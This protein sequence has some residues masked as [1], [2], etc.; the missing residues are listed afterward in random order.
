[1]NRPAHRGFAKLK[2][3]SKDKVM[4]LAVVALIGACGCPLLIPSTHART[5]SSRKG[6]YSV[7]AKYVAVQDG[8]VILARKDES[9]IEVPL[10]KLSLADLRYIDQRLDAAVGVDRPPPPAEA[11]I[12]AEFEKLP[13]QPLVP[14]NGLLYGRQ[15][16]RSFGYTFTLTAEVGQVLDQIE[17]TGNFSFYEMPDIIRGHRRL[18]P[19][20]VGSGTGFVVRA[21]GFLVT[22]AHVVEDATRVTVRFGERSYPGRVVSIVP[23]FDLAVVRIPAKNLP[24]L[25]IS[26]SEEPKPGEKVRAIG[27]P[28]ATVLGTS[29]KATRGSITRRTERESSIDLLQVDAAINPGNSGGPLVNDRGEVVGIIHAKRVGLLV[30][31]RDRTI[32]AA[33]PPDGRRGSM[34]AIRPAHWRSEEAAISL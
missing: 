15:S 14:E 23:R 25:P 34:A 12:P 7:E 17:G 33:R 13:M 4:R 22:C 9:R 21:D 11:D 24:A 6:G 10:E 27:F 30:A 32:L 2:N 1:M 19:E 8:K 29:L 18:P 28:V 3:A 16:P 31:A 5:W 20:Q 26:E